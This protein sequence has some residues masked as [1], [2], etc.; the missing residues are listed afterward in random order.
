MMTINCP[1]MMREEN[2][3]VEERALGV[4][5]QSN[6][7]KVLDEDQVDN[8]HGDKNMIYDLP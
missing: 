3:F 1:R 7:M 5:D 8:V 6:Q 2:F 4:T